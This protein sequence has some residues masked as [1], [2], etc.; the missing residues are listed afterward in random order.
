LLLWFWLF[1]IFLKH[2]VPYNLIRDTSHSPTKLRLDAFFYLW[3]LIICSILSFL[4]AAIKCAVSLYYVVSSDIRVLLKGSF[5]HTPL[6][7]WF[8][9]QF[10]WHII[11]NTVILASLFLSLFWPLYQFKN[12][13]HHIHCI[14]ANEMT[15]AASQS[16]TI[17]SRK[18]G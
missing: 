16:N 18:G 12:K 2:Y 4:L 15:R 3:E 1:P 17:V 8:L 5:L 13:K 10:V 6:W 7:H 14:V 11:I 9:N